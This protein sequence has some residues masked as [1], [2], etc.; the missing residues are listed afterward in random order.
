[1]SRLTFATPAMHSYAHR[2][3]CQ[4]V[5]NCRL[6]TGMGLS[7]GESNE[8][9]WSRLR[10]LIGPSRSSGVSHRFSFHTI[11]K[12]ANFKR[13][14][15]VWLIDRKVDVI[16]QDL[17]EQ[18]GDTLRRKLVKGVQ[19]QSEIARGDVLACAIPSEQL[20]RE[21]EIQKKAQSTVQNRK[22]IRC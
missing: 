12:S 14:R 21:W 11:I 9:L 20:R 3:D 22:W 10:S 18:L 16:K 15:R 2:W 13:S 4:V 1:M 6:Q 5:Y 8:R 19:E 17:V 7:D